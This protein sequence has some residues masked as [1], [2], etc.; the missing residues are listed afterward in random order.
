MSS[1][2]PSVSYGVKGGVTHSVYGWTRSVQVKLWD[3]LI[4][5]HT[6]GALEVFTTRRY[7]FTLLYSKLK[8]LVG[9]SIHHLQGAKAYCVDCVCYFERSSLT[10]E[11]SLIMQLHTGHC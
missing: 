6:W 4:T 2:L 7:T 8:A 9:C 11:T 3:P 10:T 1:S 5:R